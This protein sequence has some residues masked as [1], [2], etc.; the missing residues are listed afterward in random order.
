MIALSFGFSWS[1]MVQR[2]P[3]QNKIKELLNEVHQIDKAI[4]GLPRQH[5][6]SA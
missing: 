3:T 2:T 4:I 1:Y 6:K 5:G